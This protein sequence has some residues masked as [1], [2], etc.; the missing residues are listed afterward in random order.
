MDAIIDISR[1]FVVQFCFDD[2]T[3]FNI[4]AYVELTMSAN[5]I[6]HYYNYNSNRELRSF[7]PGP[8]M[9]IRHKKKKPRHHQHKKLVDLVV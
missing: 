1:I 2:A 7:R 4:S 6:K 8:F 3:N 5:T 9:S